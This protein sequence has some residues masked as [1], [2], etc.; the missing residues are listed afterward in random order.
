MSLVVSQQRQNASTSS[1]AASAG[2]GAGAVGL[3]GDGWMR[4]ERRLS[5][6]SNDGSDG[7]GTG[8]GG[9]DGLRLLSVRCCSCG[10]IL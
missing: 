8:R 5:R 7:A 3:E 4:D 6:S 1:C 9:A 2:S 10:L